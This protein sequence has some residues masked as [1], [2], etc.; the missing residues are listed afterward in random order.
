MAWVPIAITGVR[1]EAGNITGG[2]SIQA[3]VYLLGTT[4][5]ATVKLD[6]A[7]AIAGANPG[8]VMP[9]KETTTAANALTTDDTVQV[10]STDGFT[11]GDTVPISGTGGDFDVTIRAILAGPARLQ[12]TQTLGNAGATGTTNSGARVGGKEAQGNFKRFVEDTNDYEIAVKN[13]STGK[14][15]RRIAFKVKAQNYAT[16]Q[17][18]GTDLTQRSKVDFRGAMV[19]AS[20]DSGSGTTKVDVD[21]R[22]AITHS[23]GTLAIDFANGT[24]VEVLLQANTGSTTFAGLVAGMWFSIQF[25][26][27]GTGGRTIAFAST[28]KWEGG[29]PPTFTTTA[30]KID[31]VLGYYD[32]TDITAIAVLNS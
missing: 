14:W 23:A 9:H 31:K 6:S 1:D 5:Q 25:K 32:G 26:Q 13:T 17:D 11:V 8:R 18:E 2:D 16:V 7:G 30:N 19:K 27:D 10:A 12:F 15:T 22:Q 28:I 20:D 3:Y 21:R 24:T 4:T 29:T